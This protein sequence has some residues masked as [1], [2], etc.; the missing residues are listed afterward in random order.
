MKL[1]T[2]KCCTA[3]GNESSSK[4][5]CEHCGIDKN[6][7]HG[8]CAWC[9]SEISSG[10]KVCKNCGEKRIE[11]GKFTNAI[12]IFFSVIFFIVGVCNLFIAILPAIFFLVFAIL[13]LPIAKTFYNGLTHEKVALRKKLN[14]I[15]SMVL[16]VFFVVSTIGSLNVTNYNTAIEEWEEGHYGTAM[17]HFNASKGYKD[18]N[19]YIE[20]FEEEVSAQLSETLWYSYPQYYEDHGEIREQWHYKFNPDGTAVVRK[21]QVSTHSYRVESYKD[22]THPYIFDYVINNGLYDAQISVGGVSYSL[23]VVKNDDGELEVVSFSPTDF[24]TER[25][26]FSRD[27]GDFPEV[28]DPIY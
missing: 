20:K 11:S 15:I 10:A 27:T 18:S 9:G 1:Y 25:L 4:K 2:K 8:F 6:K 19:E 28:G 16:V 22:S 5:K 26:S 23:L 17:Y 3:C 12:R 21:Q 14:P 13:L 24:T 7:K